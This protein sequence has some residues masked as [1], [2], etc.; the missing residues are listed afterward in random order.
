MP[1]PYL[2]FW[3]AYGRILWLHADYSRYFVAQTLLH[4]KGMVELGHWCLNSRLFPINLSVHNAL[5]SELHF[6]KSLFFHGSMAVLFC[7]CLCA[8]H[9]I[10]WQ[11]NSVDMR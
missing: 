4:L 1:L 5:C 9:C 2:C 3:F 8:T 7:S 11:S 6:Y 10:T